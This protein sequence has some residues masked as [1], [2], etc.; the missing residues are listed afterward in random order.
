MD[1]CPFSCDQVG[2]K[3]TVAQ[4]RTQQFNLRT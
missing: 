4:S 3:I 2:C 1:A